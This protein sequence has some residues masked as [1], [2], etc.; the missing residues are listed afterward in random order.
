MAATIELEQQGRSAVARSSQPSEDLSKRVGG[1]VVV[2]YLM[3]LFGESPKELF[4]RIDV[5]AV[6]EGV[7]NDCPYR[8]PWSYVGSDQSGMKTRRWTRPKP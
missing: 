7:K 8:K 2:E 6:L 1:L 5:L 3:N 4:S